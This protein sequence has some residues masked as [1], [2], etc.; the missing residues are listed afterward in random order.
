MF[1][2]VFRNP[3]ILAAM[4]A[5]AAIFRSAFHAL[6][7]ECGAASTYLDDTAANAILKELYGGQVVQVAVYKDNPALALLP[8]VTDFG[9][10]YYPIPIIVAASAGRSSTFTNAQGNQAAPQMNEFLLTSKNDY[11]LATIQN[12]TMKAATTDK[13]SFIRTAKVLV[14]MAIREI[15]LSAGSSVY[16]SGTGS[17]GKLNSAP[18]TG[19]CTL[20]IKTDVRQFEL[21]M[22]LQA[23]ATDGGASPRAALGYVIARSVVNGTVTVATSGIGGAA[24][25]PSGWTT[26]DYLLVQ[27]D[28]NLKMSGFYSWLP[29][30]DPTSGDNQ[31]GVDRSADPW[32][33]GGGRY[34][35]SAY[36]VEEAL[37]EAT[38]LAAAES[39]GA[40]PDTAFCTFATHS[41]VKKALGPKVQYIDLKGPANIG[42]RGIRVDGAKKEINLIPDRNCPDQRL[43][44]LTLDTW[45]LASLGEYP[46]IQRYGDGLDMLRVY[47]ADASELRIAGYGNLGTNWPGANVNVKTAI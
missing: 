12:R 43:W 6:N 15:D 9:G 39:G 2:Y 34:D 33:L 42:F 28:N 21:N 30:S 1:R 24:A 41:A 36:S 40:T 26:N 8:K 3:T 37:I 11:S 35:G 13:M 18:S 46:E 44:L 19:V 14:D 23:N 27:G 25:S 16:R 29:D 4:A 7:S 32:R 47:N 5:L 17:I 20:T 31:Y 22:T 45:L 38:E 10:K